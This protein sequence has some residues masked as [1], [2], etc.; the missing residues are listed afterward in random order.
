MAIHA[1]TALS[2]ATGI[3]IPLSPAAS[4]PLRNTTL[5]PPTAPDWGLA[6]GIS[7]AG[8]AA[9]AFTCNAASLKSVRRFVRE[10]VNGWGLAPLAD[11]MT[12][13]VGELAANAI[14]HALGGAGDADTKAWLGMVRTGGAV[15]CAVVDPSPAAPS[16]RCPDHLTET[17]RG[18]LIV[19]ALTSQWGYCAPDP[20]GKTV[21][22][23]IATP[24]P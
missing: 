11:D 21:W 22:A 4:S 20:H 14:R 1:A 12:T 15:V 19:D 5:V 9:R 10:T 13:V 7:A 23:R 3:T 6:L 17:G 24:S 2:R 18:L 16:R 8:F